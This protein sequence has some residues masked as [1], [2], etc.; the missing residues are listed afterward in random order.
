MDQTF[1]QK[2]GGPHRPSFNPCMS[3][4]YASENPT[5]PTKVIIRKIC[6]V[7]RVL[8]TAFLAKVPLPFL[9]DQIFLMSMK[10]GSPLLNTMDTKAPPSP[11]ALPTWMLLS[12]YW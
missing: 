12:L 8:L 2:A 6:R 9:T 7:R 4:N 5:N 1:H 3:G 11:N 10:N